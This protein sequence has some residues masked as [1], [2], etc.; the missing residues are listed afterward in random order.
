MTAQ[1][2]ARK[3]L[4]VDPNSTWSHFWIAAAVG[5]IAVVSPISKQVDLAPEIRDE[6]EKSIAL[7]PRNGSAFH[8]YGVWH[9]KVAEIGGASRMFASMFY[10]KSLPKGSLEK[11]I[12]FLKKA[13]VLNPNM[14]ISRLELARSYAAKSEWP[15]ARTLLKTIPEMPVQFSDDAK[16]KQ[17]AAQLLDEIKDR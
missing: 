12:E 10:G 9:R 2:Y 15:A 13:V 6:V 14:I 7:D 17:K 1:D 5:S 4:R 8:V 3:A 16:N 11:S